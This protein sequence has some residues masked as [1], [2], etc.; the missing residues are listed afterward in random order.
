ME[1]I[2]DET[3]GGSVPVECPAGNAPQQHLFGAAEPVKADAAV[4][5]AASVYV[6]ALVPPK[7]GAATDTCYLASMKLL[8]L[9]GVRLRQHR[10]QRSIVISPP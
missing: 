9:A 3:D 2:H 1:I 4:P 8:T 6:T 10:L 7:A 5:A